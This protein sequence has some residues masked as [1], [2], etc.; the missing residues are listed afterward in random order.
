VRF[1]DPGAVRGLIVG[2]LRQTLAGA[3]HRAAAALPSRA[4]LGAFRPGAPGPWRP[5]PSVLRAAL[6]AQSPAGFAE[7]L[8]GLDAWSGRVD[9]EPAGADEGTPVPEEAP[10]PAGQ[11]LGV[12]RAQIL[13]TY[14][15]SQTADG[16][17]LID[18]HAAHERLVYERLKARLRD[19]DR[20]PSQLLLL[21][22]VVELDPAAAERLLAA[23]GPLA[24]L[25]LVFERFGGSAIC[26]RETPALLGEVDGA[27]LLAD[28][29]DALA[30]GDEEASGDALETRLDAVLSRMACHGSVRAGRRL[31][32]QEMARSCARWRRRRPRSP[33]TTAGRP[34]CT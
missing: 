32:P 20:I 30:A 11:P 28:V 14:I 22:D 27:A 1:R 3:G 5:A 16:I 25:G 23:A 17:A 24:R 10:P 9:H 12:P 2:A 29:A 13:E 8:A 4:A 6:A 21:P 26:L 33:A 18:Q 19:A 15:V 31:N 7:P 34:C